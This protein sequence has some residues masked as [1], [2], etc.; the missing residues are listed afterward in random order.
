MSSSTMLAHR[1]LSWLGPNFSNPPFRIICISSCY[2]LDVVEYLH[3][4]VKPLSAA[5]FAYSVFFFMG[6]I[7]VCF[8][9]LL[10]HA[11]PVIDL[12]FLM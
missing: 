10:G 11:I 6:H 5:Y 8:R 2:N 4:K 9:S 1:R 12:G 7:V 3:K